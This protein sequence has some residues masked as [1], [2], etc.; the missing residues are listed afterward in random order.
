[1]K[2]MKK[3]ISVFF[4]V[5]LGMFVAFSANA[6][7]SQMKG[8]TA[9]CSENME[10]VASPDNQYPDMTGAAEKS[11]HAV[12]HIQVESAVEEESAQGNPFFDF[13]FGDRGG[14]PFGGNR[15]QDPELRKGSGSGVIIS[16]DGYIVT[17]NHVVDGAQKIKVILND[18]RE[19]DGKVVGKDPNSDIALIKIEAKGLQ[20]LTFGNSDNLKIG[21]WVLAVGNP[22]NL[23]STVT[24]GIVSAKSR[25]ININQSKMPIESFIQTDAAVNPGN[26]GGALVNLKGELVGINT[27]IASMTGSY[28]GY[29]FAVPTTIVQKVVGDMRKYGQVKRALLGVSVQDV[30]GDVAKENDLDKVEGLFVGDVTKGGA[31]DKAGIKKGDVIISIENTKVDSGARLQEL[32]GQRN[33]GDKIDIEVKREGKLKHF[34]VVLR[35]NDDNTGV[36]PIEFL[37]SKLREATFEEKNAVDIVSGVKVTEVGKGILKD[38]GVREGFIITDVNKTPVRSTKDVVKAVKDSN[39]GIFLEGVYPNKERAYYGFG[40]K[41]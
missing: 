32:I 17:N 29:S 38:A 22:F 33:P 4:A 7:V 39:G 23:T 12:V 20:F 36:G 2:E 28:A 25:S 15:R 5:S 24:A 9:K 14:D 34:A 21:E 1:M 40:L 18:K 30:T 19:F 10:S 3:T 6:S 37:G 41:N 13:F 8:N 26:S 11:V 16:S 31:A 27:A 35:S